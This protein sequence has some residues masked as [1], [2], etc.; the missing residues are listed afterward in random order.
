[1]DS[2]WAYVVVR[3]GSQE[4]EVAFVPQNDALGDDSGRRVAQ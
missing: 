1:M 4:M 3:N 2:R